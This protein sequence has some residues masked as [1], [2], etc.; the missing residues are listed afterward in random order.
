LDPPTT[1][2]EETTPKPTTKTQ[3]IWLEAGRDQSIVAG[4]T[5]YLLDSAGAERGWILRRRERLNGTKEWMTERGGGGRKYLGKA[6]A[7][8]APLR[9]R[10]GAFPRGA[11]PRGAA[12][13]N[14]SRARGQIFVGPPRKISGEAWDP[15]PTPAH[16]RVRP[17]ERRPG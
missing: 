7:P 11:L 3:R 16:L 6:E 13:E 2:E 15:P 14:I 5:R 10:A 1:G 17:N 4:G 9:L 8:P 12:G